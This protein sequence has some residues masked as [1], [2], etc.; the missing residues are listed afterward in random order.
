VSERPD[1]SL[2]IPNDD[3]RCHCTTEPPSGPV[4]DL[5]TVMCFAEGRVAL[6]ADCP[7]H[8]PVARQMTR[9]ALGGGF[10]IGSKHRP[11]EGAP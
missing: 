11:S 4:A 10:S 2:V 9:S 7:H 1:P 3:P 8:G 6:H 5:V